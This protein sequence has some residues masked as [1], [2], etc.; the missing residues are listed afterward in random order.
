[1]INPSTNSER[2]VQNRIIKLLCDK[3]GYDYIGNLKDVENGNIREETLREFLIEHQELTS[4]QASEAIRK[5]KE[6][7]ACSNKEASTI[8]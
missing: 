4:I 3:N 2:A 7:A 8:S 6:A 5:L 1:M